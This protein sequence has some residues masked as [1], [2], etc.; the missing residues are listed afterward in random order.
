MNFGG[1]AGRF[2]KARPSHSGAKA[3]DAAANYLQNQGLTILARNY[4]CRLGELDLIGQHEGVLVFVEVRQR[5]ANG[6]VAAAD[7]INAAK[8]RKWIAAARHYLMQQPQL[9]DQP[10]RFDVV[11]INGNTLDWQHNVLQIDG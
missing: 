3:E 6:L 10:M 11:A 9:A 2:G 7:S 5:A 8:Q 4:H 1:T